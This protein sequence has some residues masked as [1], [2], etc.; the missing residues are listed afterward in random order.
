M[1]IAGLENLTVEQLNQELKRGGR[2]VIF[3]YCF[4][5]VL[6]TSYRSSKIYY[7]RPGESA[8]SKAAPFTLISLIFGWWAIPIGPVLTIN[9]TVTNVRGGKNVT[10]EVMASMNQSQ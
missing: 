2:F 7:L 4:S 5:V 3:E 10:A 9:A 8:F 1:S 6:F